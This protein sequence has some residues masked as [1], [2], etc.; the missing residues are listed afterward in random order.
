[1]LRTPGTFPDKLKKTYIKHNLYVNATECKN[2]ESIKIHVKQYNVNF[3][4]NNKKCLYTNLF[5]K[6]FY[7]K[8]IV[9]IFKSDH[10]LIIKTN[11]N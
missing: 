6:Y 5:S 7:L 11:N 1:M 10:R 4:K 2:N 9:Y 8:V 3:G